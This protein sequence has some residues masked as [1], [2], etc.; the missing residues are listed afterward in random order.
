MSSTLERSDDLLTDS[1]SLVAASLNH[2]HRLQRDLSRTRRAVDSSVNSWQSSRWLLRTL[3]NPF[4]R[5][6]QFCS[7]E[8]MHQIKGGQLICRECFPGSDAAGLAASK[9]DGR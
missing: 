3:G 7:R 6:C 2:L 4:R 1:A 8:T 5:E 9:A